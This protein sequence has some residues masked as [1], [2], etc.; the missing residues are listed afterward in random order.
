MLFCCQRQI[1]SSILHSF[2]VYL[3]LL[4]VLAAPSLA[5]TG[6][7][8]KAANAS[9]EWITNIIGSGVNEEIINEHSP[10]LA[11]WGQ[12]IE[13]LEKK[14]ANAWIPQDQFQ[15]ASETLGKTRTELKAFIEELTPSLQAASEQLE[16]LGPPPKDDQQEA[17][18]IAL[19]RKSLLEDVAAYDSLIKR[20]QVLDVQVVQVL[21]ALGATRRKQF[22]RQILRQS[23]AIREAW[24]WQRTMTSLQTQTR[25][26]L[27]NTGTWLRDKFAPL[28]PAYILI[29]SIAGAI[30][31]FSYN[32]LQSLLRSSPATISYPVQTRA[33]RG[34]IALRRTAANAAPVAL[35]FAALYLM[36]L[37]FRL[38]SLEEVRLWGQCFVYIK[39]VTFLIF[40][41]YFSLRPLHHSERLVAIDKQ[42]ATQIFW[43]STVLVVVWLGDQFFALLDQN[44]SS[45]LEL[46]VLRSSVI[47]LLIGT[48]L[49]H[50]LFVDIKRDDASPDTVKTR[51]WPRFLYGTIAATAFVILASVGLGYI[52]LAR[53]IGIQIVAMGGLAIFMTLV[54]LTA[55][56]VSSPR[57]ELKT[58]EPNEV[59]H[60][61]ISATLGVA[62]GLALDLLVLL[63]GVPLLF[64][65]WGYEWT[66]IR[67][68]L[69]SVLFGFQIGEVTVSLMSVFT[70]IAIL[71]GGVLLTRLVRGMF[72]RRSAHVFTTGTGARDSIATVLTYTGFVLSIIAAVSYLGFS[73]SN[74]ALIAGAL[75]VGIGF[76]L[77][78]V[79]NNFVSGLILLAERPIKV[80]DWIVVGDREG[81]V[82]RISVRS[83]QIRTFDRSTVIVPNADLITNQVINWYHGDITGRVIVDVGVAYGSDPRKVIELLTEIGNA[84]PLTLKSDSSPMVVFEGFGDSSMD[85]SLRV[86]TYDIGKVVPIRTD[87]RVAIVEIFEREGIEIPFPQQDVNIKH[88]SELAPSIQTQKTSADLQS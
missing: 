16:K 87:L 26:A 40:A 53:F 35:A 22:V 4:T 13:A 58:D 47:A 73:I 65:Q 6:D 60:T 74:L 63:V 76:G 1:L 42:S 88:S 28:W 39:T 36:L 57:L 9:P 86:I 38:L 54:H 10:N 62:L 30:G 75:S 78:G 61:V 52:S 23:N 8:P 41:A 12:T 24:Y 81:T 27:T 72:V 51:G 32:L 83:T 37:S 20:A 68:W 49:V 31:Y 66:E 34:A 56:F 64:L 48:L 29:A 77:Q 50:F 44:L 84:H 14:A 59:N 3:A 2:L 85:F 82:Q 67:V 69:S 25:K 33:E 55:E 80:G 70:G 71:V 45:P 15:N 18:D 17:A 11:A 79:A 43:I 5:Q 21:T 19:Q 46:Y 7:A